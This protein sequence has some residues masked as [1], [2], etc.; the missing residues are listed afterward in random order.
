MLLGIT[1]PGWGCESLLGHHEQ[2]RSSHRGILCSWVEISLFPNSGKHAAWD[3]EKGPDWRIWPTRKPVSGEFPVFS[4]WIRKFGKRDGFAIDCT[5]RHSVCC[6]RDFP[7]ALGH[8]LRNL[9][10]SA[11]S[12]PLSFGVSEPETAGS[13][14]KKRRHPR[15]SLLP[16]WAVRIRPR[17]LGIEVQKALLILPIQGEVRA[18]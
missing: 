8:S 17:I 13:A 7:R 11:G 2:L 14:P 12:W 3:P 5:H 16:S 15:L 1:R 4:L 6:C 18:L 10:D 9:R